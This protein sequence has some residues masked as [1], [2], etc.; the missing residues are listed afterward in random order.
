MFSVRTWQQ[1]AFT[2]AA[3]HSRTAHPEMNRFPETHHCLFDVLQYYLQVYDR[4]QIK[5]K[6]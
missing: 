6:T 1:S 3:G 2:F 4:C 5:G